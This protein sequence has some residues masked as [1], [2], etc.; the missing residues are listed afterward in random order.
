MRPKTGRN[1]SRTSPTVWAPGSHGSKGARLDAGPVF[2]LK[3]AET[4]FGTK[5]LGWDTQKNE[6]PRRNAG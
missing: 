5:S 6:K 3:P 2:C 1:C 4:R